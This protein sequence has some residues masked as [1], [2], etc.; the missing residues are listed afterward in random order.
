MFENLKL[1]KHCVFVIFGAT[2][3]LTHRKIMPALYKLSLNK[4]LPTCFSVVA[5]ARRDKS[6]EDYRNDV[7]QSLNTFTKK[8]NKEVVEVL[9]EKI[10]YFKLNFDS[11]TGYEELKEYLN[12]IDAKG[13]T[14]GNRIFYMATISKHVKLIINNLKKTKFVQKDSKKQYRVITEKPFGSDL[15]SAKELNKSLS[16]VFR[17]E[18][19]FRIDHYLGKESVQNLFA[20]RFAN[21]IFEP[22]WNRENIDN[23]QII[24]AESIGIEGRAGYYDKSGALRDMVQN[25]LLQILSLV[26]MEPPKDFSTKSIKDEK[27]KVLKSIKMSNQDIKN[28][29]IVGQYKGYTSEDR[30]EKNSKTETYVAMKL[31]LNNDRWKGTPFYLKTGKY[32]KKKATEIC[33]Y[34]KDTKINTFSH[35]PKH[36]PNVLV[37]RLQPDEGIY[38]RF[39]IKEPVNEFKLQRVSMDFCH[40]CLFGINTPEAYEKLLYDVFLDDLSL[41]TRWDEVVE[42]W[43]IIDPIEKYWENK[44]PIIYEK[45]SIGPLE[46][47]EML[48]RDGREW[49]L[50]D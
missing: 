46:S 10:T 14:Q 47:E 7:S 43:K 44:N 42:E 2:G 34:F 3:D 40:N 15:E 25:H 4:N 48:K 45:N 27:V 9:L 16:E 39:N 20:L 21:R 41:F 26:A 18:E 19:T 23:I 1:P 38:L 8:I 28:N 30:V 31:E 37:I 11:D 33:I 5:V 35:L 6:N 50:S 36:K 24:A 29:I 17:E 49:R 13:C 12:E 32:L 22:V